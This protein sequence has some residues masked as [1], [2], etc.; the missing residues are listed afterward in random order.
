[1]ALPV[2]SIIQR[3]PGPHGLGLQGSGLGMHLCHCTSQMLPCLQLASVRHSTQPWIESGI[4]TKPLSHLNHERKDLLS[5]FYI[6]HD[7]Y[8]KISKKHLHIALPCLSSIHLDPG[9]HGLGLQ[10]SGLGTHLCHCT[11][12]TLPCLQLAS[13]RHSTHPCIESGIGTNPWLHLNKH[14]LQ[15]MIYKCIKKTKQS[16]AAKPIVEA[17]ETGSYYKYLQASAIIKETCILHC[18]FEP[19]NGIQDRK[20]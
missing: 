14:N 9:P 13:V 3:A 12:Q 19:C 4:G 17:R 20:G 10:G 11:S 2:R 15:N 7:S 16:N 5:T 6:R 1:M 8:S 18:H